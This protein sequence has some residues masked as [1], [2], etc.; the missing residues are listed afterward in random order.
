MDEILNEANSEFSNLQKSIEENKDKI[1]FSEEYSKKSEALNKDLDD[2]TS[3][4]ASTNASLEIKQKELDKL[5]QNIITAKGNP[6]SL[7]SGEYTGG[8][9]IP[10]GRYKV[11][12]SSNFVVQSYTGKLKVNTILGGGIVGKGDYVCNIEV[13]DKIEASSKVNF[14][15]IK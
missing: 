1:A 9:D 6:I 5:N 4:L 3:K 7:P 2:K 11:S 8:T 14:T 10:I 15:P 13:G 12:G